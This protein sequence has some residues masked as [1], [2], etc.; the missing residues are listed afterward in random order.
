MYVFCY[1][2]QK[3]VDLTSMNFVTLI[4]KKEN[5]RN[6]EQ[7]P[8]NTPLILWFIKQTPRQLL[9]AHLVIMQLKYML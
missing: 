4:I 1:P 3:V 8:L 7:Q 6:K 2:R 5:R 9:G